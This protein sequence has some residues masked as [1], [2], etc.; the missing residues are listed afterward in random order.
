MGEFDDL[1]QSIKDGTKATE[2]VLAEFREKKG[3]ELAAEVPALDKQLNDAI[4]EMKAELEA[5]LAA[6]RDEVAEAKTASRPDHGDGESGEFKSLCEWYGKAMRGEIERKDFGAGSGGAGGYMVP[7]QFISQILNIPM[8]EAIVRPRATIV[9]MSSDTAKIPALNATSHA[10]NFYGGMLGY[11]LGEAGAITPTDWTAKEVAL[12]ISTLAAAGKVSKQLLVDSPLAMESVI[13]RSFGEII[14][15]MEDQAFIDGDGSDK[16]QGIIGS[17][18]E[19]AVNRAGA[20][21][22]ATADVLGM[23]ARFLGREKS[24][25]WMANRDTLPQLYALKD[26][27]N[28]ALYVQNMGPA[29]P[30]TLMGIPLLWTE[31][32]SALGTKGDLMLADWSYYLIGDR[33][34]VFIDWSDHVAF[35][36]LQSVVRLYERIDGKPW[37]DATHT[38]RKGVAKSPFVIL[39]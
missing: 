6:L 3:K 30:P 8:E 14:A 25:V 20:G 5:D 39:N 16:P 34:Q 26:G 22:I 12:N 15:F 10:T 29:A 7:D 33:Q 1:I 31:K 24:A 4:A 2:A 37:L 19:V 38:P 17:T 13:T 32:A 9:P 11:W 35:L 18:C 23:L 21:A 28:N 27:A 36:N